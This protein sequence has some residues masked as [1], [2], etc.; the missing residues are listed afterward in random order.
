MTPLPSLEFNELQTQTYVAGGGKTTSEQK[1]YSVAVLLCCGQ[2][3]NRLQFWNRSL[4]GFP[5][6]NIK[7]FWLTIFSEAKRPQRQCLSPQGEF[8]D[9]Q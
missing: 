3:V 5:G 6:T 1:I 8:L 4:T 9:L 2:R 7:E